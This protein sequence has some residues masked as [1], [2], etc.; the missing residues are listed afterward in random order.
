MI[1]GFPASIKYLRIYM[2]GVSSPTA[3]ALVVSLITIDSNLIRLTEYQHFKYKLDGCCEYS[4]THE[5]R[6][7]T[8]QVLFS[9]QTM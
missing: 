9:I 3:S 1:V 4:R 6:I 5:S 8:C 7:T 2:F